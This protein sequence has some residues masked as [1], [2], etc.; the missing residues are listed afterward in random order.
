M[1]WKCLHKDV[2]KSNVVCNLWIWQRSFR[3]NIGVFLI[4]KAVSESIW[5][6]HSFKFFFYLSLCFLYTERCGLLSSDKDH[7]PP[8][9]ISLWYNYDQFFP[10]WYAVT[11][12]LCLDEDRYGE[13]YRGDL[14]ALNNDTTMQSGF[15]I[16]L[17]LFASR[18]Q[19]FYR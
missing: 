16:V 9:C 19:D 10:Y 18:V 17:Y 8:L 6:F 1:Q 13:G 11:L 2:V 3:S 7:I 4:C 15:C 14:K 5:F 12:K